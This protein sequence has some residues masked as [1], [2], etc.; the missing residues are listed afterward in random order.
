MRLS[1]LAI[2]IALS[3]SGILQMHSG[4]GLST[5]EIE[6]ITDIVCKAKQHEEKLI[7]ENIFPKKMFEEA[8]W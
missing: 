6:T 5:R 2:H 1:D 3:S 8:C 7:N 4:K